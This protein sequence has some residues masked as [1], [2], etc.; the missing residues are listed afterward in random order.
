MSTLSDIAEGKATAPVQNP[1]NKALEL[2]S[3]D[4]HSDALPYLEQSLEE[5]E[6]L[7]AHMLLAEMSMFNGDEKKAGGHYK[8]AFELFPKSPEVLFH[9]TTFG[10]HKVKDENDEVLN[11]LLN[12][13]KEIEKF[14]P[15]NQAQIYYAISKAYR[16]LEKYDLDFEYASKGADAKKIIAPFNPEAHEPYF[17]AIAAYFSKELYDHYKDEGID[18]KK[19]VFI[20]GMPRTGTTLVEQI[21]HSHKDVE[22]IG[23]DTTFMQLLT[24]ESYL[25]PLKGSE[26]IV[27]PYRLEPAAE[28]IIKSPK[29]IAEAYDAYLSKKAPGALRV[30]NKAISSFVW[31]G[32]VPICF[33]N[34]KIIFCHRDPLDACVSS[35][36]HNF[37]GN[38]QP[39]T[40]D[41]EILGDYY[42]CAYELID[43]WN[44]VMEDQVYNLHYEKLLE[45][46]EK[47]TRK[48]IEFL[49]L[50]WDPSCLT[51]YETGRQVKTASTQQIR[52]PLN[53]DS[54]GKHKKYEAF[55]EP[56]KKALKG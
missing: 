28:E 44:E 56:L 23:E 4:K 52:R 54:A 34:A 39:Y 36:L 55:L 43:Y 40:N 7:H 21:L 26:E 47:E 27:Y 14:Q 51:F 49:E 9:L 35:Y 29:E 53:K 15:E 8:R 3:E 13:E 45:D 24:K 37:V 25:P 16:D 20:T 6:T 50:D 42:R 18:S 38:M 22:G 11:I 41:L 46:Q 12:L 48:L 1:L 32:M 19:P 30:V 17:G 10:F 33:P 5:Q 31:L 2:I